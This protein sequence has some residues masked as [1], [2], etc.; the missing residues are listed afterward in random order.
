MIPIFIVL[1]VAGFV[2]FCR[3]IH[4]KD[5]FAAITIAGAALIG[6]LAGVFHAPGVVDAWT[7]LEYGLSAS[8]LITTAAKVSLASRV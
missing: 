8:G 1:A 6:V 4:L 2:E 3:R 7:G 5:Y